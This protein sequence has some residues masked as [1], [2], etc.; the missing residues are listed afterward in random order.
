MRDLNDLAYFSA[1][2]THNGFSAAARALGV[3]KSNISRRVSRLESDL[4]VRLL[5][6]STRR[7]SVTEVGQE[8]YTH[9]RAVIAEAE[10]A[11]E[12]AAKVHA[13]PSGL[14][15]VSCP[16]GL[17]QGNIVHRLPQ[18][19]AKHPRLRVQLIVTNRRIDLIGEGVDI[20][21]RARSR[22]DTDVGFQM[23][24]FGHSRLLMTASPELV[25]R[26]GRPATPAALR[27]LPTI[28]MSQRAGSDSWHLI[29]PEGR[30][31]TVEIEPRLACDDFTV[32]LE[33]TLSG[34]GFAL[35]PES[36][37]RDAVLAG[38]LEHILPDWHGG[39]DTIHLVFTSRRGLLPGVRAFIDFLSET[40]QTDCQ[41]AQ[42]VKIGQ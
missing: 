18:F 40:I 21:V 32:L 34:V 35:L 17:I 23:K 36:A 28:S 41:R 14:V 25:S 11:E 29:G 20:A 4:G 22:L 10:A 13:E 24:T 26:E 31:E 5:E 16:P 19:L 2:V 30:H 27:G 38:R 37:C 12:V 15:R 8:F 1:V 6:R 3:P 39:D 7:F 33:A 9:C 42:F